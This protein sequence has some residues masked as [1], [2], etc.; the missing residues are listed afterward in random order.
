[1]VVSLGEKRMLHIFNKTQ[2][3]SEKGHEQRMC[4]PKL[5][6]RNILHCFQVYLNETVKLFLDFGYVS[7]TREDHSRGLNITPIA[8][9]V[10]RF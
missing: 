2:S 5:T 6:V 10:V 1:M 9:D 8:R 4:L 3:E 7:L